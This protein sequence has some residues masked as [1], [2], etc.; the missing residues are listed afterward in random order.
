MGRRDLA[1][2]DRNA[3]DEAVAS[4]VGS[5]FRSIC[6]IASLVAALGAV[7]PGRAQEPPRELA[8]SDLG[9]YADWSG[10]YGGLGLSAGGG[11]SKLRLSPFRLGG[12][13]VPGT[14]AG[15]GSTGSDTPWFAG[16]HAGYQWQADR[17]V[18]GLEAGVAGATLKRQIG[19]DVV[20]GLSPAG[21]DPFGLFGFKRSVA[22][23]G[24]GRIGVAFDDF[25]LYA[26]A[27]FAGA[28]FRGRSPAPGG[29]ET[30]KMLVGPT[31][32]FGIE[33]AI[34]EHFSLG[35]D[36]QR[37]E[38]GSR[39]FNLGGPA[40]DPVLSRVRLTSDDVMARLTWYPDGLKLAP[41]PEESKPVSGLQDW[42]LHGQTTF[43]QQATPRFR[44]P[45]AGQASFLP[46]QGRETWTVTGYIGRRLWDGAE[47]YFNPELNQGFG[48]S[49]TLGIAG[50]VNGEAQ[51]AGAPYPKYR[52]QRYF[53]RQVFGLGGETE[54][55]EDGLNQ[56]AGS[57]DV[58]RITITVGKFAVG[59][60]FDD[61]VYAHDPRINFNNWSLWAST[62]FDFPA[63]LPGF[64][65][66]A[67]VEL[68]RK[69]WA[70]RAGLFQV[71]K[72]PASDVLDPRI[73][74]KF[75][76]VIELETRYDLWGRP[77][78]WRVGA[79]TNVGRSANFNQV[80]SV[81]LVDPSVDIND[82]VAATRRDR[83]KSGVYSN[84]EQ[85][86]TDQI[87][88]FARAS[89][90]DGK[91]ED[92]SFTDV[93]RSLSGGVSIK[94]ASW[95]RP[96]DTVGIG[97]AV[98][99]LSRAHRDYFALGGLGLLIGDGRLNYRPERAFETYYAIGLT[100]AV[101]LTL[102]YQIVANPGYNA[103]RGPAHVVGTRLHAEF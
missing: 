86:V 19:S 92:L 90:A 81:V 41:Q 23:F 61:N 40:A 63:N 53:I 1:R 100:D 89:W 82:A 88:V 87:G 2:L 64:T 58:D 42:S 99:A 21:S 72:A 10:P 66:G 30:G 49:R 76:S 28:D 14:V 29:R 94:G 15:L 11:F 69:D 97:T 46:D 71:P 8:P 25:L 17:F 65:Q 98:N 35:I 103:D 18:A 16:G 60:F 68:N 67:V 52:S 39:A 3:T 43:I 5:R 27:G 101:K 70:L 7:A 45:Y 36:F 26:T 32:G 102:D 80:N 37:V 22:A 73:G 96:Q 91:N 78:K 6:G 62:A 50:Y 48:L 33:A 74:Q 34:S 59:D 55:V 31:F 84:L 79:F 83:R 9:A 13:A 24:R 56:I 54:T 4:V 85:A 95:G 44:S 47:L 57:R 20:D 77:G 75:G 93:D 51:K 38:F 12:Q